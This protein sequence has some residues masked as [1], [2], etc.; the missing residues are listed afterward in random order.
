LQT[1]E[2]LENDEHSV[3]VYSVELTANKVI[4]TL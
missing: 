2:C 4:L 1:G 3:P